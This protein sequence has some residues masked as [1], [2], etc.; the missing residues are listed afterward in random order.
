LLLKTLRKQHGN[1]ENR[2]KNIISFGEA[3][4]LFPNIFT[5]MGKA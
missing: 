4:P 2:P 5:S 3:I 1:S